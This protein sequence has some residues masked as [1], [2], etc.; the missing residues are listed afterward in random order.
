MKN[1]KYMLQMYNASAEDITKHYEELTELI[2]RS[3]ALY[4]QVAS[5]RLELPTHNTCL[6]DHVGNTLIIVE[7]YGYRID[8]LREQIDYLID[9]KRKVETLCKKLIN[10]GYIREYKLIN[11]R[12][13][14][15]C[16]MK[17]IREI[18]NYSRRQTTRIHQI[19]IQKLESYIE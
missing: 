3:Q 8:Y 15:G 10:E 12:Y 1:I 17:R 13:F 19:A 2:E 4:E 16:T 5:A 11:L 14:R 18:M 6:S 7:K 9:V